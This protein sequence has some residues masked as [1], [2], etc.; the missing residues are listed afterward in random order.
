M[1]HYRTLELRNENWRYHI[2]P[3]MVEIRYPDD[4][5]PKMLPTHNEILGITEEDRMKAD[6]EATYPVGP[7]D[8]RA[9]IEKQLAKAA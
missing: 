4:R 5:S 6:P 8:I 7:G 1:A 2:G 3:N 9:Y